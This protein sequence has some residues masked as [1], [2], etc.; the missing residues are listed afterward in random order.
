[1]GGGKQG[2]REERREI[3]T[4]RKWKNYIFGESW[5]F[6]VKR[7]KRKGKGK[8]PGAD[9]NNNEHGKIGL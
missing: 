8:K 2:K 1:M 9:N 3:G 6:N 4:K 7:K 5:G